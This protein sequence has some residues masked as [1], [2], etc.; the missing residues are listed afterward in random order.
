MGVLVVV[1]GDE[2]FVLEEDEPVEMRGEV[3]V[4]FKKAVGKE[5]GVEALADAAGAEE[6]GRGEK[7]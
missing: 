5:E 2:V 1:E 7:S 4:H 6:G 3:E